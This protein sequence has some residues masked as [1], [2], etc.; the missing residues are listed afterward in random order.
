MDTIR[1]RSIVE[2]IASF[3]KVKYFTTC[4]AVVLMLSLLLYLIVG[5]VAFQRIEFDDA[6]QRL[7]SKQKVLEQI[8]SKYNFTEQSFNQLKMDLEDYDLA[9]FTNTDQNHWN[10]IESVYFCLVVITTIGYGHNVP[11]TRIGK[12]VCVI[13]SIFGIPL[14]LVAF[15]T[16]GN[17]INNLLHQWFSKSTLTRGVVIP[18]I[19]LIFLVFLYSFSGAGIF[20]T[21]EGWNFVDSFYFVM[22]TFTTVGFGDF[23]VTKSYNSKKRPCARLNSTCRSAQ[24]GNWHQSYYIVLSMVYILCGLILTGSAINFL[25]V[26]CMV[27]KRE[28][29]TVTCTVAKPSSPHQLQ[30]PRAMSDNGMQSQTMTS[31]SDLITCNQ[32]TDETQGNGHIL[33]H[34]RRN[35][36]RGVVY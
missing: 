22:M 20:A 29:V 5:A 18:Q 3:E 31:N 25:I 15:Q 12:I 32:A 9:I 27:P 30:P 34:N 1:R 6:K 33:W 7:R 28:E 21:F 8:L 17:K 11:E 4:R 13:Y 24:N 35:Q 26:H 2:Q 36:R 19:C 16:V 14:C 10:I 23:H